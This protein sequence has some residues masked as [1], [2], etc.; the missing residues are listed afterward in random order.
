MQ[1]EQKQPQQKT[2]P[3]N[4]QHPPTPPTQPEA[5][6]DISHHQKTPNHTGQAKMASTKQNH[7]TLLSSQRSDPTPTTNDQCKGN[8]SSLTQCVTPVKC[9]RRASSGCRSGFRISADRHHKSGVIPL[10]STE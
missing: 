2:N 7:G 6:A 3:D 1:T 5:Q 8:F 4:N 10:R 9:P